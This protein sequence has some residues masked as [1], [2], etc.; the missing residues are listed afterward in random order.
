MTLDSVP[1]EAR[2]WSEA[3]EVAELERFDVG[4]MPLPDGP[5]ERG[6]CGYKLIQ[7]MACGRPVVAS[8][9]GMSAQIVEHGVTGLLARTS[10]DWVAA[11][12][13]LRDPA[14]RA[15]ELTGRPDRLGAVADERTVLEPSRPLGR[16]A[17][18]IT[19]TEHPRTNGARCC[20][21]HG[22]GGV[23]ASTSSRRRGRSIPPPATTSST[24]S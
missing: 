23:S 11:L 20:A 21:Q 12:R 15:R 24:G 14:L 8:P 1:I 17:P 3:T 7:Y 5:W 13:A 4:I 22:N 6:K 9:V 19:P 10:A 16:S 2:P 18:R